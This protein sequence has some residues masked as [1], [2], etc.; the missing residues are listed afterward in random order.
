MRALAPELVPIPRCTIIPMVPSPIPNTSAR[1][2]EFDAFRD[3]LRAYAPSP[4]G[5]A[6]IAQLAPSADPAW[7]EQQHRLTSEVREFLRVGS[8]FE[9]S[10]LLDPA[11]LVEKSRIAGAALE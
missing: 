9:F 3:L 10:G 2:L 6:R 4:L 1:V 7:V 5:Q 11:P 8:R